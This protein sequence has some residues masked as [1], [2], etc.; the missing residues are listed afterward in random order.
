MSTRGR[1]L[2]PWGRF[3]RHLIKAV[4]GVWALSPLT[5]GP[6]EGA[7]TRV[8]RVSMWVKMTWRDTRRERG[9]RFRAQSLVFKA[10][11][12]LVHISFHRGARP[13]YT[14]F[15]VGVAPSRRPREGPGAPGPRAPG[16]QG[17]SGPRAASLGGGSASPQLVPVPNPGAAAS[18]V[19]EPQVCA[20]VPAGTQQLRRAPRRTGPR[21]PDPKTEAETGRGGAR[22][23]GPGT[24]A[25]GSR[26]HPRSRGRGAP[27]G[28]G[29][30]SPSISFRRCV[31]GWSV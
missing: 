28:L 6:E 30:R 17:T 19:R 7:G 12:P 16:A 23:R 4:W 31:C 26:S 11:E 13:A 18:R 14:R 1:R 15:G 2:A 9:T 8:R 22:G 21:V 29:R 20:R 10:A 3:R 25:E 5:P 24:R 27:R